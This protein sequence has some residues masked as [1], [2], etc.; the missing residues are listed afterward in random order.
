MVFPHLKNCIQF[1]SPYLKKD[2]AE[3]VGIQKKR[4]SVIRV[5]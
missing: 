5:L 4:L 1:W 3:I 2:R